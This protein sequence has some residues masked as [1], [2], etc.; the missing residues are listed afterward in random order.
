[1]FAWIFSP[2]AL[3]FATPIYLAVVHSFDDFKFIESKLVEFFVEADEVK[4][5][6]VSNPLANENDIGKIA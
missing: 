4:G 3:L 2:Y 5:S 1:M 6:E